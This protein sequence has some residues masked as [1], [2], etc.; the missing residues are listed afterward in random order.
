MV[1][2]MPSKKNQTFHMKKKFKTKDK[3]LNREFI[4]NCF[5]E[6]ISQYTKQKQNIKKADTY[7]YQFHTYYKFKRFIAIT[8]FIEFLQSLFFP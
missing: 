1:K 2:T 7:L 6:I 4:D 3:N 5:I 8:L